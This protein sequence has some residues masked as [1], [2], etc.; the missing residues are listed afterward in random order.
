MDPFR[1][2]QIARRATRHRLSRRAALATG[3]GGLAA[4]FFRGSGPTRAHPAAQDATPPVA[5]EPGTNLPPNV[6]ASMRQPGSPTSAYSDRSPYEQDVL[7]IAPVPIVSFAPLQDL[8]GIIT[9]NA[10]FYEVSRGGVPIIDP[11][12]HRLMIHGLVDQPLLLTMDDLK[13]FPSVSRIH[14]LECSGNS[15]SE[16]QE[17]SLGPSVQFSHGLLGGAEWTGVPVATVLREAGIQP[18]G[19][20][21]LAEAADAVGATRSIPVAKAMDDAILV[22]ASNGEALLPSQGYPL[23]LLLPGFEGNMSIKWLRRLEVGTSP[24]HTHLE[25]SHY[26]DLLPDGTARQFTF[27]MEAKSVITMPSGGQQL[28]APGFTMIS[29]LAWSGR[30]RITGVDVSADSGQTWQPATLQEPVRP[31]SLTRFQLPWQWDGQA[32]RL[33]SRAID[34]TGYVQPTLEELVAARGVNSFYHF[35][36]IQTW[37]VAADGE[38]SNV[39]A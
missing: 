34:E 14:F 5:T 11:A 23:R 26:T 7:R 18:G 36:A 29:G 20:W 28:A 31:V 39:Y 25:T 3:G 27:A 15:G 16:W 33:Q 12:D 30:G 10:L 38:V 24:W 21:L 2:R 1:F 37:A 17:A 9:P 6:P 22:Y 35:N 13:R 8:H 4:A 32:A 19:T